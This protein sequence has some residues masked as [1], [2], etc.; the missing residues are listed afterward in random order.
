MS[1]D[2]SDL[3]QSTDAAAEPDV[4]A[5]L[6]RVLRRLAWRKEPTVHLGYDDTTDV[7]TARV[8]PLP[9]KH[10]RYAHDLLTVT[11]DGADPLALPVAITLRDFTAIAQKSPAARL[12]RRLLGPAAWRRAVELTVDESDGATVGLTQPECADLLAEWTRYARPVRVVGVQVLPGVLH[13]VL[14]DD[15][16]ETLADRILELPGVSPEAVAAGVA[17]LAR[18]LWASERRQDC[19]RAVS[20]QIGGPMGDEDGVVHHY[21]KGSL[22]PDEQWRDV[23]LGALVARRTGQRVMV[24]NDVAALAVVERWR[25]LGRHFDRYGLILVSEGI[26][27]ALVTGG[28]VC[29]DSPMEIGTTVIQQRGRKCRCGRR[30]C[31]E[32]SASVWGIVQRVKTIFGPEVDDLPKAA[33]LAERDPVALQVFCEAGEDLA[34]G[35]GSTQ[36]LLELKA[37]AVYLPPELN[38][39]SD[40]ALAYWAG[41]QRF[42]RWVSFDRFRECEL[43]ARTSDVEGP[44]GAAFAALERYGLSSPAAVAATAD[45]WAGRHAAARG[46]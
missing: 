28:A 41:V 29:P 34:A 13:A 12:S 39:G 36:A 40:A 19:E 42:P 14:V 31:V 43:A 20:V 16:G 2:G 32:A 35:I 22:T 25:G 9:P 17:E 33:A 24:L 10:T 15:R 8:L 1:V 26:G 37:L 5:D 21:Q 44:R 27:G 38:D 7:L 30:G 4:A 11:L 46:R 23:D 3:S 6:T 45:E 18:Q